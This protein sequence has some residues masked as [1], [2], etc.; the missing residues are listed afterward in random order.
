PQELSEAKHHFIDNASIKEGYDA[1][2]FEVEALALLDQML[3]EQ[4]CAILVGGSGLYVRAVTEGFDEMPEVDVK[5]RNRLMERL[6]VEGL[7]VLVNELHQVDPEYWSTVDKSN[8][9]RVVRALEIFEASGI[10]YSTF[11]KA[12]KKPRPFQ[13]VKVGLDWPRD[14]LYQ[15]I[16]QR[17]DQMLENGLLEEVKSLYLY[18]D[19]NALQTVGYSEIFNFLDNMYDWDECVRLLKRNSRRYAKRQLTWFKKDPQITWFHPRNFSAIL[20]HI[21]KA[22]TPSC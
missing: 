12:E 1:G 11:R 8:P 9:Q 16:D 5:V 4:D 3:K 19:I 7:E 18:K 21:Q 6:Q 13:L 14:I 2:K 17:M 20:E 10:P 15:R 22:M